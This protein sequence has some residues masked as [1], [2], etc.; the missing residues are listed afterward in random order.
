MIFLFMFHDFESFICEYKKLFIL[1]SDFI[2]INWK[3]IGN[4]DFS[5][6]EDFSFFCVKKCDTETVKKDVS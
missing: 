6:E 5:T 3:I 4:F 1:K 2:L